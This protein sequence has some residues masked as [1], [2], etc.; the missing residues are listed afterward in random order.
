MIFG[1]W[2][3]SKWILF[4]LAA[5]VVASY[6]GVLAPVQE[7]I[8]QLAIAQAASQ[9]EDMFKDAAGRADAYITVFLFVFLSPVA[10]FMAVTIVIFLL[11]ALSYTLGPVMGGEKV[12]VFVL[13]IVGATAVYFERDVWLPHLLYFVGLFARAYLAITATF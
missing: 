7:R 11:S 9:P 8:E 13:A 2:G 4:I 1:S 12:A 6:F 10:L 3:L 5:G